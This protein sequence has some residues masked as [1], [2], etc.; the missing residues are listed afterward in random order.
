M[1][2]HLLCATLAIL[3]CNEALADGMPTSWVGIQKSIDQAG[4]ATQLDMDLSDRAGKAYDAYSK[5]QDYYK[6]LTPTDEALKPNYNPAGAPDIPS[7]CMEDESCKVCYDD[8]QK[9]VNKSRIALEK[10]R[11]VNTYTQNFTKKGKDVLTAA[12]AAGGGPAGL[13]A[14]DEN[15]KVDAALDGFNAAVKAK[16][17][18]LLGGLEPRL[19]A[20]GDCEKKYFNNDDWY[21]RYGFMYY[22]FMIANYANVPQ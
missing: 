20:L 11:A 4:A 5:Y 18:E 21:N 3:S 7:H 12:G 10:L 14:V 2:I 8:A 22:Q 1:K 13:A 15:V 17:A 6:S 19:K 16:K 9:A